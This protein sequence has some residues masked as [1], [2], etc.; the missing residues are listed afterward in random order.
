MAQEEEEGVSMGKVK[1]KRIRI[2]LKKKSYVNVQRYGHKDSH[3]VTGYV[4]F[5]TN[6]PHCYVSITDQ[7]S[8]L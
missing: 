5:L 6:G 8:I 2:I 3:R 1:S 4:S 7:Y